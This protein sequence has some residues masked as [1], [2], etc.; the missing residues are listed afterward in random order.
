MFRFEELN[1]DTPLLIDAIYESGNNKNTSDDPFNPLLGVGNQGGFRK[2]KMGKTPD[3]AFIVLFTTGTE[4]EWPDFLDRQTGVFRYYGDNR[5]F[6]RDIH[7]TKAGG[8]K[9]LCEAFHNLD[10][11]DRRKQIPPFLLFEKTGRNRDV[12]FLGLAVPGTRVIS[13]DRE[14]IAFWRTINGNRFQNYEAHL[15]VLDTEAPIEWLKARQRN[16]SNHDSLAPM[17]WKRYMELGRDGIIPLVTEMPD[18]V[19]SRKAQLPSDLDGRAVLDAI[20]TYYADN[21]TSF[22]RCAIKIVQLMDNHFTGFKL[23]RPRKDGGRDA[24]CTY[25]IG[26]ENGACQLE[27]HCALEAKLYAE[28]HGVGVR[29][30]SRLISRIKNKEFG[31]LV[32]T[33]YVDKQAYSEIKE[34]GHNILILNAK[35]IA[36]TLLRTGHNSTN[37][38]EW[39]EG[40][41]YSEGIEMIDSYL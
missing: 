40:I 28:N 34:D 39:L 25:R 32:T 10:S 13:P 16:D 14:L 9:A 31:I 1:R 5:T 22:E 23:T 4:I 2:S 20:R 19:P 38:K 7:D 3:Y 17:A 8:N 15:T 37:I 26:P 12:K 24:I 29:W 11:V 41:D 21:P 30:T 18:E 6:G 33:S 35:D 27:L 36:N